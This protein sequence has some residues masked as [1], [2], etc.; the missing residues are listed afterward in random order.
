MFV[1]ATILTLPSLRFDT[2]YVDNYDTFNIY[3]AEMELATISEMPILGTIDW[4]LTSI[5]WPLQQNN[6]L[7]KVS[8]NFAC[9]IILMFFSQILLHSELGHSFCHSQVPQTRDAIRGEQESILF[10]SAIVNP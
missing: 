3:G 5:I 9:F 10:A 7:N 2:M 1:F 6:V 4:L 8:L